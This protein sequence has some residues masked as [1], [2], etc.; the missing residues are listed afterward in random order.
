MTVEVG[1]RA[2]VAVSSATLWTSADAAQDTDRIALGTPA[3]V[4]EWVA[5]MSREQRVDGLV[6]RSLTQV[7]MGDEVIVEE[8]DDGWAKVIVVDQPT[9]LDKR[10]Y[11]GWLPTRQLTTVAG[12]GQGRPFIV[13]ATATSIRDE[14]AGEV[15]IPGVS[16]GTRLALFDEEPYRGWSRVVLPGPQPPGWVR[17]H[18]VSE[19]PSGPA[20]AASGR[21]DVISVA[22]QLLDIP[23]VWGG[24][25]AYGID[26]SGLVYLAYRQLG[27]GLPR[28]AHDQAEAT[29]RI[30]NDDA[31]PGDLYFFAHPGKTIHHVGIATKPTEDGEPTMIHAAGN[32]GKI[33]HETLPADRL[34]TLVGTHRVFTDD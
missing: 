34:R 18:D 13:S 32:Y 31:K 19:A 7:F 22:S 26:C 14:P 11:P 33:V 3:G 20:A 25:S 28:D 21:V 6:D 24:V 17:L 9:S 30:D 12:T 5:S 10:G 15:L 2:L 29:E 16:V 27:H 23:Y 8:I 1:N 4:R